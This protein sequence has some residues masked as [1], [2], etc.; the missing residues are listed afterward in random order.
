MLSGMGVTVEQACFISR[1]S[2]GFLKW[3][4][5][6]SGLPNFP[7]FSCLSMVPYRDFHNYL[8]NY[9]SPSLSVS[10]H[11]PWAKACVPHFCSVNSCWLG[12]QVLPD[13]RKDWAEKGCRQRQASALPS[14]LW[15]VEGRKPNQ[16][17]REVAEQNISARFSGK[18]THTQTQT[19]T[20]FTPQAKYGEVKPCDFAGV[21]CRGN[22][23]E[24]A[25]WI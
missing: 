24:L 8:Y 12:L 4:L 2:D 9:P 14:G 20:Q 22:W 3:L 5:I 10:G 15:Q 16:G 18:N 13:P 17:R 11:Q 25:P 6:Y 1:C 21:R 23:Q 19:Q 7:R